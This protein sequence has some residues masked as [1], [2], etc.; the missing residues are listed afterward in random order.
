MIYCYSIGI[1][2]FFSLVTIILF[3]SKKRIL[4]EQTKIFTKLLIYNFFGLTN[5]LGTML[6]LYFKP[7][8]NILVGEILIKF[9]LVYTA[10]MINEL[11][12]YVY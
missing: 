10:A 8:Y 6:Y 9:Y 7:N 3:F 12:L 5:E 11:S 4:N 2:T 1:T